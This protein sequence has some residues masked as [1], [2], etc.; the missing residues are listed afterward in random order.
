MFRAIVV[1]LLSFFCFHLVLPFLKNFDDI[2]NVNPSHSLL[3]CII[4]WFSFSFVLDSRV[5]LEKTKALLLKP[6]SAT[7]ER[8]VVGAQGKSS[9]VKSVSNQVKIYENQF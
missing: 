1:E 5:I 3:S 6:L 2:T 4:L 8:V 9:S 7:N